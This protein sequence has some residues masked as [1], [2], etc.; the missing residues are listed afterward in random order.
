M[1]LKIQYNLRKNVY[2]TSTAKTIY[3]H[4]M[5]PHNLIKNALSDASHSVFESSQI[6][7][8][9][10]EKCKFVRASHTCHA[11]KLKYPTGFFR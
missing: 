8:L 3:M 10:G 11:S 6:F 1:A 5:T 9:P 4:D 2:E 7:N